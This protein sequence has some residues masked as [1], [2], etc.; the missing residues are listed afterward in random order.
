MLKVQPSSDQLSPF[1]EIDDLIDQMYNNTR[2]ENL[3]D[4]KSN[5]SVILF[6][7]LGLL[8]HVGLDGMKTLGMAKT[9]EIFDILN[10]EVS[11][12]K[13]SNRDYN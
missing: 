9:R 1:L 3:K 10:P 4:Y 11:F 2:R 7:I 6:A 12:Q 5:Y 13:S 8:Q